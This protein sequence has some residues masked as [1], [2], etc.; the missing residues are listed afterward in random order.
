MNSDRALHR[1][2][3]ALPADASRARAAL[4]PSHRR[5]VAANV[6]RGLRA[7]GVVLALTLGVSVHS[8]AAAPSALPTDLVTHN[9]ASQERAEAS[10][11]YRVSPASEDALQD[12][13]ATFAE[14]LR[15]PSVRG[16]DLSA[17]IVAL[18]SG[19][20]IYAHQADH[21]LKPASNTKV[22]TTAAAFDILGESWRP[23][24]R[25][26]TRHKVID[27][28]IPG[29]VV[30]H[31]MHDLSWSEL[32][33]PNA[34]YPA[35]QLVQ[36][37]IRQGIRVIEGDLL[38]YG[39]FVVRGYHFGTLD[40]ATERQQAA[41]V[42]RKA[43]IQGGVQLRG[44][45]KVQHTAFEDNY[46][47]EL[48]RWQ[49]PA[50][51]P[52]VDEINRVS[53]NEFADMILL[54]IAQKDGGGASYA[55]GATR[56]RRWLQENKLP[57]QG[58]SLHDGSGLSHN[59]RISADLL[60]QLMVW[61][62]QQPWA[63][64]WNAS[65]SPAGVDGTYVNRMLDASTRGRALMKSG[66][67]NGVISTSGLLLHPSNGEVYAVSLLMNQVVHQPSARIVLDKIVTALANFDKA[68]ARPA[69][70][71]LVSARMHDT[72]EVL[73]R[74]Q[75]TSGARQYLIE[76]RDAS[77]AW[78]QIRT[79][80]RHQTEARVPSSAQPRAYRVRAINE[81]G[82]S[83]PSVT[84]VAGGNMHAERVVLIEGNERWLAE[85]HAHKNA[86]VEP[87]DFLSYYAE[88]LAGF[89]VETMT[90]DAL[91]KANVPHNSTALFVLG[92]EA[93]DTEALS[94]KER[95]WIEKHLQRGG[96]VIVSGAEAAWDLQ[97]HVN[98][99]A[100]YLDRTFGAVFIA[101]SASD[102]VACLQGENGVRR[103]AT[104]AHFW[105]RGQM[106]VKWPDALTTTSGTSCMRY[107]NDQYDACVYQDGA[108]LIGFPL[109]SIDNSA[110]R[111]EVLRSL[112]QLV[113]VKVQGDQS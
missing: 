77:G 29:D 25:L 112:L 46:P 69:A 54:A 76:Q 91:L 38:V 27:D 5:F 56:V 113:G 12:L 49:G 40:T 64:R 81:G 80:D 13:R 33:Y 65:L 79:V 100:D 23:Q 92:R 42:L 60:T 110:D 61:V 7:V 107:G 4:W 51:A 58:L 26:L 11:L 111:T 45:I 99:G 15:S 106:Q 37:L 98:D 19:Q 103:G 8:Y 31:G 6:R 85:P 63:D 28:R 53:H 57:V 34:A 68:S 72:Q 52:V 14:I 44:E 50:L 67:I 36:Q 21:W 70:P 66:T 78:T 24:S 93:N 95:A 1:T 10:A 43:L 86:R 32:F 96:K 101:D 104:C 84:M 35:Q 62:Q 71:N 94:A 75:K 9:A 109:E 108:M 20:T 55:A 48:A 105:N 22:L 73:L 97:T 47:H 83:A 17:S 39:L 30:L 16:H 82:I 88:P 89:G 41:E 87:H 102:T 18:S 90:N 3:I 59:N 74:W 2:A